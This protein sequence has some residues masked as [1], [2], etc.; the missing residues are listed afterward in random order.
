MNEILNKP[1]IGVVLSG[2]LN[3]GIYQ[4]G[5]LKAIEEFFGKESIKIISAS[6]IGALVAYTYSIGRTEKLIEVWKG[7]DVGKTAKLL[8]KMISNSDVKKHIFNIISEDRKLDNKVYITLWNFSKRK[9]EY[10]LLNNIKKINF[11]D[12]LLASMTIPVINKSVSI[13]NNKYFDGA[14]LD[15]I[16]V[17]PL[18]DKELDYIICIYFDGN[19]Y[20][21]ENQDFNQKVIKMNA[22]PLEKNIVKDFAFQP[23]KTD[24]MIG[25]G[26]SYAKDK[27]DEFFFGKEM[28]SEYTDEKISDTVKR[29]T[30][31]IIV[32]KLNSVMKRFSNREIL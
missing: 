6:S 1:Q 25:Y 21:F 16:P 32:K 17:Y 12:Y 27:L 28:K 8:P 24:E 13:H 19:N 10:C 29:C 9:V 15:N 23:N 2:G 14:L 5:C 31:D 30:T 22:F 20:I 4:I 18:I 7:L 11:A 3:K 26:Y